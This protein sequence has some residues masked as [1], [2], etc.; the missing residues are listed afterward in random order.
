LT[1]ALNSLDLAGINDNPANVLTQ[2]N[3]NSLAFAVSQQGIHQFARPPREFLTDLTLMEEKH[4][5]TTRGPWPQ[6]SSAQARC[7]Q[8]GLQ[9]WRRDELSYKVLGVSWRTTEQ[10]HHVLLPEP[11]DPYTRTQ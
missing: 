3:L 4:G 6:P 10:L 5:G 2:P 7:D 9:Q 8:H 11:P 1:V